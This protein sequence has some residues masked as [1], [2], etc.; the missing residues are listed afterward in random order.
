MKVQAVFKT[1]KTLSFTT[2]IEFYDDNGRIYSLPVSGT[3]DNCL[4]TNFAYFQRCRGDYKLITSE[5]V[6]FNKGPVMLQL[7]EAY[8]DQSI[9]EDGQGFDSKIP[10]KK[11]N[12]S[13]ISD[14]TLGS[15]G[16]SRG[17]AAALG[18]APVPM[19][20]LE[21]SSDFIK[22]WLNYNV[23]TQTIINFPS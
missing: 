8:D 6:N 1:S 19:K 4:F 23:L 2:K 18:Y 9:I 11:G 3:S 5:D 17:A 10:K 14:K 16:S 20:E 21:D 15:G 13:I 22:R 12:H 7:E